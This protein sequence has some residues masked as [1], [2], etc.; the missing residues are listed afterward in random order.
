MA[1]EGNPGGPPSRLD[2]LLGL[3]DSGANISVRRMAA[4]QIGELVAAHPSETRPVLKSVRRFLRSTRWETRVAAGYAIASIADQS[5]SFAAYREAPEVGKQET[6]Q[7][8]HV[9][10]EP[11]VEDSREIVP[12]VEENA[13]FK[14][15][16]MIANPTVPPKT[17]DAA[18]KYPEP[19]LTLGKLDV[20]RVMDSGAMLFGSAGDE[21]QVTTGSLQQQRARLR[22]DLGID[23]RFSNGS[24]MLGLKDEDL[25]IEHKEMTA[26]NKS[27][28]ELIDAMEGLSARERNRLKREAKKRAKR[29]GDG[30]TMRPIKRLRTGSV[31]PGQAETFSL[32]ALA[33]NERDEEVVIEAEFG[34]DWWD[35]QPTCEVL[36]NDLLD[37]RWE[38]R[39][40][41]AVGMREVLK[42]HASSAGRYTLRNG[43]VENEWWL[44]DLCCRLIWVLA[45]DRFG[46][47]VGDAVVA[48]VRETAAMILGACTQAL[49]PRVVLKLV[50]TLFCLMGVKDTKKWEVR[51]AGLLGLRYI[52]AVRQD[53][54]VELLA[55]TIDP[56]LEG[57]EDQDDDVRAAAGEAL[58]PVAKV[59]VGLMPA[60]IPKLV[61]ILWDALLDLDDISA[62]TSSVLRLLS[63]LTSIRASEGF[64]KLWLDPSIVSDE[65]SDADTQG[66]PPTPDGRKAIVPADGKDTFCDILVEL[67]PRLWPFLRHSSKS[68]RCASINLLHTL[69][70]SS[71]DED[72]RQWLSPI[73]GEALRRLY[74]NILL[75]SEDE[76]LKTSQ[77]VWVRLIHVMTKGSTE[78]VV[79]LVRNAKSVLPFWLQAVAHE[80]RA[81]A[82]AFDQAQGEAVSADAQR[83]RKA[84]ARR[85]AKARAAK[86]V[87]GIRIPQ[88]PSADDTVA[89][90]GPHDAALMQQNVGEALGL[91][92][93]VW[94]SDDDFFVSSLLTCF[95]SPYAITRQI[96]CIVC[97]GWSFSQTKNPILPS[98]IVSALMKEIERKGECPIAELHKFAGP[99][100]TD[101]SAFMEAVKNSPLSTVQNFDVI[102]GACVQGVSYVSQKDVANAALLARSLHSQIT[103]LVGGQIWQM[104][105]T[106][107]RNVKLHKRTFEMVNAIRMRMLS[108]LGYISVREDAYTTS[109]AACAAAGLIAARGVELPQKVGPFIKALMASI[110]FSQNPH[111]QNMAASALADLSYRLADRG[112]QKA[113]SLVVKNLTKH[114]TAIDETVE[115]VKEQKGAKA[116]SDQSNGTDLDLISLGRR[117]ASS[118]FCALCQ[119]FG[120]QVFDCLPWLWHTIF[121]GF[122]NNFSDASATRKSLM[123]LQCL[124]EKLDKS[125][126]DRVATL[127]PSVIR[128]AAAPKKDNTR[129]ASECLADCVAA[130]P[131]RGMQIVI[132]N[133]LPLLDGT[134][135]EKEADRLVRQ[136][137]ALS[138]RAVVDKLGTTLIPYAAF[139][140]VPMM[141]R[142]VDDDPIV[143]AASAGVFGVLVGLIPLEGGAPDD[144]DMSSSMSMER[145]EARKFLGQLLGTEPRTHYELPVS[146]GDGIS[147]RKYQQDCLDWLAFLNR[148]GLHGALCDDMGLGKTLM[149][150]CIMAGDFAT[151]Q[152][153]E[154]VPCLPSLVV[155]P[156]T[157]VAHWVEEA[158]RFFGHVF[159]TILHYAGQP[160]LRARIRQSNDFRAASLVVTSYDVLSNDVAHFENVKWNYSVL[161]EGHVIKNPKTKVARAV[162]K[163]S[164]QHRLILTGTPIQNSVLELWAMFDFLMPGF[165]GTEASFKEMYGKPITASRDPKCTE[166]DQQR[167]MV[168]TESLHRQVLPFIL[169]RLKDDVLQ[170]LPPKI[171]QDYYCSMTKLQVELY[172]DFSHGALGEGDLNGSANG[173]VSKNGHVFRALS[174]LRRLCSHP[175]LVLT[176]KHPHFDRISNELSAEGRS[177]HDIESS[178]KLVGLRNILEECGIGAAAGL[179]NSAGHRV[180]I[181]AQLKQM[182]D[183]VETD[184]FKA[185]MPAVTYMR[186]D[187][188]VQASKR[189]SIVT[190]FN[191]DPS[192]DC[193]LLTTH[194]GGLGLNLTGADT[195]IFLE[196]DWNPTKDLQAMDR[197]H[198][199]GQ[200]RTVNVYRLITRGTLEDKIMGIQRFKTHIA[201]TIVNRENS[202][203]Q[204]MNTDQ[205]VNL[206]RID[207]DKEESGKAGGASTAG[208]GKG[209]KAALSGLGDLWEEK[210]Y[211]DEFD[212]GSFLSE[213]RNPADQ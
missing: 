74:R 80:T 92:A 136:G 141:K 186:L 95:K 8:G 125:L 188:S 197:A 117:G 159:P 48:P 181:F 202:S 44:E 13:T 212:V 171:M 25:A 32:R 115:N 157:I 110:R 178:A 72:L 156:S 113:L 62:S 191:A 143:R 158:Q 82:A 40:G 29:G 98:S 10:A 63:C 205:L 83:R 66:D 166:A 59:V 174:Y 118:A 86:A 144:P 11:E 70:N 33:N 200:K 22:K 61:S 20:I 45:M 49:S 91:L 54:S 69:V 132:R 77:K 207:V 176:P 68:V 128:C 148:Y 151:M 15:E 209:M 173:A 168:A 201:N 84:A 38:M 37:P 6:F 123:V 42:R 203:L 210:Q 85:A 47:F 101:T 179:H 193:L 7:H 104:W 67:V 154:N 131:G 26:P 52:I 135:S 112:T 152:S 100:F 12:K 161:D 133:L 102:K 71:S 88:E 137:A 39:H 126:I 65:L 187:G 87:M 50:D 147:L 106:Y 2:G 150:L 167:G 1:V 121:S 56:I 93:V 185:H 182:L 169:R 211:E 94:P 129:L 24:D 51:H 114:L 14:Q 116:K 35:F 162:R 140:I 16:A 180:L 208:M 111:I 189:Q 105:E 206:F 57:L 27:A 196:H 107:V 177:V 53:M 46:D 96:A 149:T 163:L 103:A 199:M 170:E 97:R 76:S 124:V 9:K 120:P 41:A 17:E 34:D 155:C 23:D 89:S 165:L 198:R 130:L 75:E 183:I 122:E 160:R 190:R 108:A 194:V 31:E 184:L 81:D 175:K 138:L 192:I 142:M 60:K 78:H 99:L 4:K 30:G 109:L 164:P 3:L 134:Q 36:K 127:L 19:G 119:R 153:N 79:I 5:P 73:C 58:I 18:V 145:L 21:Y 146:I 64:N 213:I 204:S 195:V 55:R 28:S 172:E 90:E 139:L 43:N